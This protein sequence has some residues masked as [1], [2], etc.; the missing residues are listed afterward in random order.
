MMGSSAIGRNLLTRFVRADMWCMTAP[1]F[2]LS[3]AA[4]CR[5]TKRRRG[6]DYVIGFAGG[7]AGVAVIRDSPVALR[8]RLSTALL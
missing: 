4:D 1:A 6:T 3:F 8:H 7:S 2:E 5:A